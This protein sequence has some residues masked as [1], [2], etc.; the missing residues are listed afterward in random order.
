MARLT[1]PLYESGLTREGE[2]VGDRYYKELTYVAGEAGIRE[3]M[4]LRGK[5]KNI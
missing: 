3:R 1:Y 4:D 2:P 5:I